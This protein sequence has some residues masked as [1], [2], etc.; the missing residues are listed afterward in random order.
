[1]LSQTE[2]LHRVQTL[3]T[4]TEQIGRKAG[5][6]SQVEIWQYGSRTLWCL[7][8]PKGS[9]QRAVDL[10]GPSEHDQLFS[11][12]KSF[13]VEEDAEIEKSLSTSFRAQNILVHAGGNPML[14]VGVEDPGFA[15]REIPRR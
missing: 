13:V 8:K 3:N 7:H 6:Q 15:Q 14:H 2:N 9:V 5:C 4:N 12:Q 11:R 1:M 10:Q